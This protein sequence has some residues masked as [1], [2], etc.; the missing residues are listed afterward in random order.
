MK[1]IITDRIVANMRVAAI[2]MRNGNKNDAIAAVK[3][4]R[5]MLTERLEERTKDQEKEIISMLIDVERQEMRILEDI[6]AAED[7][8]DE[9]LK[10]INDSKSRLVALSQCET[11]GINQNPLEEIVYDQR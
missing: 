8:E 4:A 1:G 3:R 11:H 2:S 6:I 7:C 10:A 5:S 9:A